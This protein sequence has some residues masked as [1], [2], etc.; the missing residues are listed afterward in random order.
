MT[1][2]S[3]YLVAH[4]IV[5]ALTNSCHVSGNLHFLGMQLL[6]VLLQT[7]YL[8]SPQFKSQVLFQVTKLNNTI[9]K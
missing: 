3:L 2:P 8:S 7:K 9:K 6:I 5:K 4:E 1:I